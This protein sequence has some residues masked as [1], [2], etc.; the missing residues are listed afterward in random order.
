MYS[1]DYKQIKI[2]SL[3]AYIKSKAFSEPIES[4]QTKVC[5]WVQQEYGQGHSLPIFFCAGL[6]PQGSHFYVRAGQDKH[7]E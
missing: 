2:I 1:N 3:F 6:S 7:V 5:T 4:H